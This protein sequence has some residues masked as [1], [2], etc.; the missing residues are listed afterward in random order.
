MLDK[1]I[2]Y[3]EKLFYLINGAHTHFLDCTMWLFSGMKVWIPL[4]LFVIINII[5]KKNW[6]H[7]VPVLLGIVLLFVFCDQFSSHLI[8]PL[9][10]RPRPTHYPGIMEHVRIL[11]G[12]T[13]GHYGFISG[14]A[15]N[16][17][18]FAMFTTLLF[19]NKFYSIVIFTW[20]LIISY[21]RIYLGVHFISDIVGGIL[22]G[23]LIGIATF[24]LFRFAEKKMRFTLK[25]DIQSASYS[26]KQTNIMTIV[27]VFYISLFLLLSEYIIPMI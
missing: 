22:A 18:G 6:K 20:A 5:Y 15:T 26:L 17:F 14:H 8:K 3:E 1:L 7:W 23:L 13:G 27:I 12:Y 10:A 16:S 25:T 9:F 4:A 21:S 2:P 19:R 11:Y 24:Y